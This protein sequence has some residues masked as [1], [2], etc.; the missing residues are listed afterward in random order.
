MNASG[1]LLV[2][3]VLVALLTEVGLL[4]T[5]GG[6]APVSAQAESIKR[7]TNDAR[8]LARSADREQ[9]AA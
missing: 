2:S 1:G 6:G 7:S 5:S 9:S 4:L 3:R 8:R